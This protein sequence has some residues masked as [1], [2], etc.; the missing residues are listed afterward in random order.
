MPLLHSYSQ[1]KISSKEVL[2]HLI[3]SCTNLWPILVICLLLCV[4]A[5]F[6]VWVIE[7]WTNKAEF[8]R[9]FVFGLFEGFWWSFVS[10]T[11]VGYGDKAPKC[12]VSK[13][14]AIVWILVGITIVSTFTASL[15]T[16][17]TTITTAVT[18]TITGAK[19]GVLKGR[20]YE[21]SAIAKKGGKTVLTTNGALKAGI[22]ELV[23]KLRN[24]SIS[25]FLI[26]KDT[27]AAAYKMFKDIST[28]KHHERKNDAEFFLTSL[29]QTEISST[30]DMFSYGILVKEDKDYNYFK[31]FV[32]DNHHTLLTC[33]ELQLHTAFDVNANVPHDI[34]FPEGETF[35][36]SIII[37]AVILAVIFVIGLIYEIIRKVLHGKRSKTINIE[38][39]ITSH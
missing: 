16:D 19:I 21:A 22:F 36:T 33:R 4:I 25:G 7:T 9:P 27:H 38:M 29:L 17:I 2:N 23:E 24:E 5:G 39:E 32:E 30:G 35:K 28:Q 37:I 12:I 31:T 18:P 13:F 1:K 10:M 15:T 6:P 34:F 14:V 26:C 11:T 3:K 8:P 20:V